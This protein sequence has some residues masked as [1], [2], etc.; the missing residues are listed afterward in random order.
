MDR[1]RICKTINLL[2]LMD[3]LVLHHYLIEYEMKDKIF[4]ASIVIINAQTYQSL[5]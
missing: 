1:E 3:I 4:G 2:S 5:G